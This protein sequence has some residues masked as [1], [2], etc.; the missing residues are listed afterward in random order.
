MDNDGIVSFR[1]ARYFEHT[2][3]LHSAVVNVS[4]AR[5]ESEGINEFLEEFYAR[6]AWKSETTKTR[7]S[8]LFKFQKVTPFHC[9]YVYVYVD[10]ALGTRMYAEQNDSLYWMLQ[11]LYHS[12]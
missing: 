8:I 4:G 7:P 2:A 10:G 11:S 6:N 1:I 5:M 12:L 9:R 3:Q